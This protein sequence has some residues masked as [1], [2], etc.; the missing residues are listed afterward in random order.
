A[1]NVA[2]ECALQTRP[3]M[4]FIGEEVEASNM[5]LAA[6]TNQVVDMICAR[7]AAG[8]HYGVVLLPGLIGFIPEFGV[9]IAE[10]NDI[11]AEGAT[12]EQVPDKLSVT[13]RAVF[14]LVPSAIQMQLMLDRDPHGNVQ[15]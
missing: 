10:I 2:L 15:V 1:A 3:N 12:P 7:A 9:L 4:C 5:S 6:V 8:K 14:D 11:L 13:S